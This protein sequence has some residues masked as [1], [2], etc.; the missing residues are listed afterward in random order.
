MEYIE[1]PVSGKVSKHAVKKE[2]V[3][4]LDNFSTSRILWH[5][6]KRHK[7]GLITTYAIVLTVFYFLPFL[8]SL[9]AHSL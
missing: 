8:P 1:T 6:V 3:R 2:A 7:L 5:V 4:V 9:L